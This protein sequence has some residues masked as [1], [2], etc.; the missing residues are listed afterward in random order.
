MGTTRLER[1][2]RDKFCC[3]ILPGRDHQYVIVLSEG[4]C[5]VSLKDLS[6]FKKKK[7]IHFQSLHKRQ[8]RKL[9][10]V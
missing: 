8:V 9:R 1:I 5:E 10:T 3:K 6:K 7:I 4:V 2:K